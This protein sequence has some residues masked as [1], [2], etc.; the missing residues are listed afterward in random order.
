MGVS[1]LNLLRRAG[2]F[3]RDV[4]GELRKVV[5]PDRRTTTTY[6][7]VVLVAVLL[8]AV[9]IWIADTAFGGGIRLIIAR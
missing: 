7:T 2:K 1:P 9:V 6:T 5:W 3:L 4:R 8:V